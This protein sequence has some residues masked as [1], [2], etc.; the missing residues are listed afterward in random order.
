M[1]KLRE[2]G[3]LASSDDVGSAI[4]IETRSSKNDNMLAEVIDIILLKTHP[5]FNKDYKNIGKIKIRFL[6][7]L[8][9]DDVMLPWAYPMVS[10]FK[11]YPVIH[12]TV[13]ISNLYGRLFYTTINY[14]NNINNN[15][16]PNASMSK[17]KSVEKNI[18]DYSSTKNIPNRSTA[19]SSEIAFGETFIDL[20]EKVK[21]LSP[22]EGDTIIQGR[23]G[24]TIRL[25]SDVEN[26]KPNIKINVG[27]TEK[28]NEL[29]N[30]V[31]Y[32]E[33]LN[34]LTS[35]IWVTY[36]EVVDFKAATVESDYH[37]KSAKTPPN[38]FSGQ[39][40]ILN[41]DRIIL[42]SKLNEIQLYSKLGISNCTDGYYSIDTFDDI[43]FSSKNNF[44]IDVDEKFIFKNGSGTFID[45]PKILL[46]KNA[47]E[48]VVMGDKLVS[49]LTDLIDI[50]IKETHPTG[51]GPSGPPVNSADYI[52]LKSKLKT[53]LSSQN[54]TL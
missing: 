21:P 42:N 15:S 10:S 12:E 52:K 27:Q 43:S 37:L 17:L 34:D 20:N 7:T 29:E 39:Q 41:S 28:T 1:N 8:S 44:M 53:I 22:S 32:D 13:N 31:T 4:S 2:V 18:S 23:F 25:G 46:G 54:K 19:N 48:P 16:I 35:Q 50:I 9:R 3:G 40:I 5:E 6:N 33:D 24:N 51:T 11:Q 26:K 45:S 30:G 49:I 36:D 47:K 14:N 38:E